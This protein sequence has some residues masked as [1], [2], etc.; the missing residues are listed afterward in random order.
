MAEDHDWTEDELCHLRAR[1]LDRANRVQLWYVPGGP[2]MV[3]KSLDLNSTELAILKVLLGHRSPNNRTIPTELLP[4]EQTCLALM[5]AL[6]RTTGYGIWFFFERIIQFTHDLIEGIEFMH[7]LGIAHCDVHPNNIVQAVPAEQYTP[8]VEAGRIYLID[9]GISRVMSAAP[10][11]LR[12][13][14]I[15][16]QGHFTP[17]EGRDAAEPYSYDVYCVGSA[18]KAVCR[19]TANNLSRANRVPPSMRVFA[20]ALT[21]VEPSR[22]PSIRHARMMFSLLRR[23]LMLTRWVHWLLPIPHADRV[24]FYGWEFMCRIVLSAARRPRQQPEFPT[25][26]QDEAD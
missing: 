11:S 13:E 18:I 9:F 10:A 1:D 12:D 17:P 8:S 5:P 2:D 6:N 25:P 24:D 19:D 3:V 15:E 22:R 20:E 7:S 21:V 26:V 23:W 16:I 4:C 14:A